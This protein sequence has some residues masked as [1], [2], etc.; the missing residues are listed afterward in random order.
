MFEA[1]VLAALLAGGSDDPLPDTV[2]VVWEMPTPADG[3]S[4]PPTADTATWPQT[5]ADPANL[6]CGVWHQADVYLASEAPMFTADGILTLG[7]D[8]GSDSQRGAISWSF[9][10]GGDCVIPEPECPEG[11]ELHPN[12]DGYQCAPEVPPVIGDPQF[13]CAELDPATCEDTSS[14]PTIYYDPETPELAAT[15]GAPWPLTIFAAALLAVGVLL[16]KKAVR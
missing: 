1:I 7:E 11:Q 6:S 10:Y 16:R 4:A 3:W 2:T 8:F 13:P 14:I 12:G 15:G 9:I 5:L